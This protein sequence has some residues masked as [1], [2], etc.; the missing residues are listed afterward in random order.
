MKRD[1]EKCS[2]LYHHVQISNHLDQSDIAQI[3]KCLFISVANEVDIQ[4]N[5][6]YN[7]LCLNIDYRSFFR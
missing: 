2:T 6:L 1:F 4:V 5:F 7:N 3:F